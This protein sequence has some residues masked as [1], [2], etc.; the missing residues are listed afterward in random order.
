MYEKTTGEITFAV[1]N[2]IL[3]RREKMEELEVI[4]IDEGGRYIVLFFKTN[5]FSGE[6]HSSK[7]GEAK[8]CP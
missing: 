4:A 1:H 8:K 2:K 7:E 3:R 6:L 5:K